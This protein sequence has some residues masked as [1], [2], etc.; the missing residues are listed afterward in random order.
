M[1]VSILWFTSKNHEICLQWQ[2]SKTFK[3][4]VLSRTSRSQDTPLSTYNQEFAFGGTSLAIE[5]KAHSLFCVL[6]YLWKK[7]QKKIYGELL[8]E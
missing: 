6:F 5:P 4:Y 2:I 7:Y 1:K 8:F 3:Y